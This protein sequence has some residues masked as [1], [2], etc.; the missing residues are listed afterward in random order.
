VFPFGQNLFPND[1]SCI[2]LLQQHNN[3]FPSHIY[4]LDIWLCS[5]LILRGCGGQSAGVSYNI[6]PLSPPVIKTHLSG[7][8]TDGTHAPRF[9]T[10][11]SGKLPNVVQ[12]M[13][14]PAPATVGVIL[15][16]F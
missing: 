8:A 12:Y 2:E 3:I 6:L 15:H 5:L 1:Q 16:L 9:L 13:D 11:R 14:E 4:D 10:L 7:A